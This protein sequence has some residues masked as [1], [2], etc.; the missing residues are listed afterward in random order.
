MDIVGSHR[1]LA[2]VWFLTLS[3]IPVWFQPSFFFFLEP[4]MRNFELEADIQAS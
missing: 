3:H 1:I 4:P 2:W